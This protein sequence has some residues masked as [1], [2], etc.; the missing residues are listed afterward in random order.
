MP[1]QSLRAAWAVQIA[2]V[3]GE[4]DLPDAMDGSDLLRTSPDTERTSR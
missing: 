2:A 1:C 3:M 4:K